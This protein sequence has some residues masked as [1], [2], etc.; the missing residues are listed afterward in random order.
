VDVALWDLKGRLHNEP[1]WRL[2][3]GNTNRIQAYAGGVDLYHP[4]DQLLDQTRDH[5]ANG[6]RAIKMKVGRTRLHEDVARVHA[7]RELI[8]PDVVLMVDANMRSGVWIRPYV[9]P[10]L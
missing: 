9:P 8:G 7:M 4:L 10:G 3:G 6:F 1:L 2:L 5:I